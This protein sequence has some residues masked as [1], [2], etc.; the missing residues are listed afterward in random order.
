MRLNERFGLSC[1]LQILEMHEC[2]LCSKFADALHTDVCT[3]T[4]AAV[5]QLQDAECKT[6]PPFVD[7][8]SQ[9]A[10]RWDVPSCITA[11]VEV[12]CDL[13][14]QVFPINS[15]LIMPSELCVRDDIKQL[16]KEAEQL[17]LGLYGDVPGVIRDPAKLQ[18]LQQL[19]YATML[20]LLKSRELSTD[21]EASVLVLLWSWFQHNCNS[22]S[23]E[24]L[25]PLKK[26]VR[27]SRLTDPYICVVLPHMS[28]LSLTHVELDRLRVTKVIEDTLYVSLAE[29]GVRDFR[30]GWYLPA[31]DSDAPMSLKLEVS[32]AELLVL[33]AVMSQEDEDDSPVPILSKRVFAFGY[34]WSLS[35]Q[36]SD[37]YTQALALELEAF[38]PLGGHIKVRAACQVKFLVPDWRVVV[39][40]MMMSQRA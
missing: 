5:K 26:V 9:L 20:A 40:R 3:L 24:Q 7:P 1:Q 12:L 2:I 13:G 38:L 39:I 16:Q 19:P 31:R 4:F 11:C 28:E 21:S 27:Y 29:S 35:L 23:S 30:Y 8:T 22:C 6:H 32:R 33:A 25:Q 14:A 37:S 15:V 17:L 34:D 10:E 36:V 18:E